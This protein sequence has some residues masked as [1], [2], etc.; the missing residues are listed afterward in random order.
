M[1]IQKRLE[2][3]LVNFKN[4]LLLN[5]NYQPEQNDYEVINKVKFTREE[6]DSRQWVRSAEVIHLDG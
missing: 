5:P 4:Y 6:I 1:A 2:D 3:D